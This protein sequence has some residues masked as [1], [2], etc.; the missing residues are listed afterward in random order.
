V[1]RKE[2]KSMLRNYQKTVET[3]QRLKDRYETI[4]TQ[5]TKITPTISDMPSSHSSDD[6]MLKYV[7]KLVEIQTLIDK[8][9]DKLN[10]IDSEI[11]KLKPYHRYIVK[12]IDIKGIPPYAI[13]RT[14][15]VSEQAIRQRHNRIIDKMFKSQ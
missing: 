6:K 14:L 15:K 11:A 9:T 5:A 12:S 10:L 7:E 2:K 4:Y 3:I 1:D 8:L 13:A